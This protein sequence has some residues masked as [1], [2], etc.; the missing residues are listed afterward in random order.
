M[1]ALSVNVCVGCIRC[2][3]LLLVKKKVDPF[4]TISAT[5]RA[6]LGKKNKTL[7]F[8]SYLFLS[9]PT[10]I[11]FMKLL[12]LQVQF[13]LPLLHAGTFCLLRG[14]GAACV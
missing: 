12:A 9:D 11:Y 3:Y 5:V 7:G 10:S 13:A 8:Y 1:Y 6:N 2:R 4:G 14:A